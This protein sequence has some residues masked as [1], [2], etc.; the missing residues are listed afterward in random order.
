MLHTH[1]DTRTSAAVAGTAGT[2]PNFNLFGGGGGGSLFGAAGGLGGMPTPDPAVAASMMQD[3]AMMAGMAQM[4]AQ[5]GFIE[6]IEA[7]NPGLRAMLDA[8]PGSREMLRNPE[9]MRAMPQMMQMFGGGAGGMGGMGM[10]PAAMLGGGGA[11]PSAAAGALGG[12]SA[13]AGWGEDPRMAQLLR[14]LGGGGAFGGAPGTAGGMVAP[15]GVARPPEEVYA[16][17]LLQ[18]EEMGLTN[19]E[20]NIR[21]LQMSG[22]NVNVAVERIFGGQV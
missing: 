2:P 17:Q 4:M 19:R 10:P 18:L 9:L 15:L 11:S 3:P 22:G 7:T 16:A 13:A 20:Q 14:A 6:M 5:P 21:A 12:P 8:Q 1:T